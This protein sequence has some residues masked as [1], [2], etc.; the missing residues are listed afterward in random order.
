[1]TANRGHLSRTHPLAEIA[2]GHCAEHLG[3]LRR[4]GI[5]D[6]A[7]GRCWEWAIRDDERIAV[8]FGLPRE[9]EA[10]PLYVDEIA[11]ELVCRGEYRPLTPVERAE[12][13][14]RLDTAGTGPGTV[15]ALLGLSAASAHAIL[16][17]LAEAID[18]VP[19]P[20][21]VSA[22]PADDETAVA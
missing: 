5:G 21:P 19:V 17:G 1:M 2:A 13:V 11:V 15:A 7:C 9:Y 14:R 18:L 16:A 20:G 6:V 3:P 10:D 4:A 12:A 22:E 8:E